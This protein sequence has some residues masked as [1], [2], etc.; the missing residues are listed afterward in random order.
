MGRCST[1]YGGLVMT[2]NEYVRIY[3]LS[4]KNGNQITRAKKC[5]CFY[6]NT[7]FD[8]EEICTWLV[9]G[10]G[11]TAE[12]PYCHIDSVIPE[13][14]EIKVTYELLAEMNRYAFKGDKF[15]E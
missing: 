10:D 3:G 9:D 8:A 1:K 7:I 13:T 14:E 4:F 2:K 15:S 6:C 12:C 5:G 11:E